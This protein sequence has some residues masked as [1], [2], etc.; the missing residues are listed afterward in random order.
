[1][2]TAQAREPGVRASLA[3]AAAAGEADET[4][5]RTVAEIVRELGIMQ[6]RRHGPLVRIQHDSK[7]E[8][9]NRADCDCEESPA[10]G[11]VERPARRRFAEPVG[12]PRRGRARMTD[13]SEARFSRSGIV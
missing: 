2:A 5:V 8:N 13:G 1:M 4:A 3:V 11:R 9:R 10:S 7:R 6:A 12:R